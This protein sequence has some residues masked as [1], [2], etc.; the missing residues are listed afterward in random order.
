[1]VKLKRERGCDESTPNNAY[2]RQLA[3]LPNE[4]D[5]AAADDVD[6][7]DAFYFR[8]R[9]PELESDDASNHRD[10]CAFIPPSCCSVALMGT[11]FCRLENW[12]GGRQMTKN[13][14]PRLGAR[15]GLSFPARGETRSTAARAAVIPDTRRAFE[16]SDRNHGLSCLRER[17]Q[18]L[19]RECIRRS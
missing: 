4:R 7:S 10:S 17:I 9:F 11:S 8:A 1:M 5:R 2:S 3:S 15:P 12:T 13:R 16:R 6:S 14:G 18:P 19:W